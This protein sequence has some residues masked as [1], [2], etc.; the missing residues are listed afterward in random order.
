MYYKG[1]NNFNDLLK[2]LKAE[3]T[4]KKDEAWKTLYFSVERRLQSYISYT[5]TDY[6]YAKDIFQSSYI[7]FYNKIMQCK[8]LEPFSISE[9]D[10]I[11]IRE[12]NRDIDN[13]IKDK[14]YEKIINNISLGSY[15]DSLEFI[16]KLKEHNRKKPDEK[17][18]YKILKTFGVL[19]FENYEKL[20]GY[21]ILITNNI[22]LSSYK[23]K[24]NNIS[25]E[26]LFEVNSKD[27]SNMESRLKMQK[28]ILIK[29]FVERHKKDKNYESLLDC[30][31]LQINNF[32]PFEIKIITMFSKKGMK[33]KNIA[34]N[35]N[36]FYITKKY[37]ENNCKVT[38]NRKMKKLI[39][40]IK[41]NCVKN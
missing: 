34:K 14:K 26:E 39:K 38:F 5:I 9:N 2:D 25:I 10:L 23:E 6:N 21:L 31:N 7:T 15:A 13:T 28:N 35:L 8:L 32:K 3:N 36:E 41:S 33:F 24:N 18:T 17:M 11:K 22:I 37:N 4:R 27:I 30:I 12:K 40:L 19:H 29:F 20:V 16:R 1:Y